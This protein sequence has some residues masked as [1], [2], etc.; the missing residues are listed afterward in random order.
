[1]A[2]TFNSSV[3]FILFLVFGIV[4]LNGFFLWQ[5]RSNFAKDMC[6]TEGL[7]LHGKVAVALAFAERQAGNALDAMKG[8]DRQG[9][10]EHRGV[11]HRAVLLL[12]GDMDM[13]GESEDANA[14][15]KYAAESP[16][17]RACF[18]EVPK[19]AFPGLQCRVWICLLAW[20]GF[21]QCKQLL[22]STPRRTPF[23]Q[24]SI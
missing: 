10:C 3:A 21:V 9:P 12:Y 20:C 8:W 17:I 13:S 4:F 16:N 6:F 19:S 24:K 7:E 1:M 18:S 15:R 22:A 23:Q 11:A 2:R 5:S 14:L